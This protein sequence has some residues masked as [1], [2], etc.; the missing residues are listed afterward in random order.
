MAFPTELVQMPRKRK[1]KA[2]EPEPKKKKSRIE[3]Q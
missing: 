2:I 3:K 1:E